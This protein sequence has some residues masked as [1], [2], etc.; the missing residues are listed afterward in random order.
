MGDTFRSRDISLKVQKKLLG[1]MSNKNVAKTLLEDT[2]YS[3]ILD[4]FYC[5]AKAYVS[6]L[7][8][9]NSAKH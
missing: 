4:N 6:Y 2:S 1:K 7:L 3:S 9:L 8:F 5:L